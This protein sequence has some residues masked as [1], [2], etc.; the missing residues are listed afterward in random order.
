MCI[1]LDD[2]GRGILSAELAGSVVDRSELAES[3][4]DRGR[5][6]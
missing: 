2:R 1:R 5:G 6:I 4:D 3:A